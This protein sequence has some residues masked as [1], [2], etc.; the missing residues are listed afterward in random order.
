[1]RHEEPDRVPRDL[2]A[3]PEAFARLR[4]ALGVPND[5]AVLERCGIDL[6]VVPGPSY[7]GQ[8]L[9]TWDTSEGRVVEDLWGVRRRVQQV[10]RGGIEW[11]YK[12]LFRSPLAD[13]ETPADVDAYPGWPDPEGWDF[14]ALRAQCEA[15]RARGCAVVNAGDRLDRTAQL[16]TLMY[17]RGMEQAYLDLAANLPLVEA[18]LAHV[19]EYFLAYNRRVFEVAGDLIDV[20]MMG[21]DFGTQRGPI[22]RPELWRRLFRPGLRA[23]IDLAHQHGIPVMHHTCGSVVALIPDFIECGLD[24]LQSLQPGAEGMDLGRLKREFGCDL[25]FHGS[26][27]I[28]RTFP[29]GTPADVR[30]E[31]RRRM[32]AGQPGGGF[33]IAPAHALQ[34][35]VPPANVEAFVDACD[36]FGIH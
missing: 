33:I 30:E 9:R 10:C 2:W 13:A 16:K 1:L 36:E 24:I 29:F 34:P 32:E 14:S 4:H 35:D 8:E 3:A 18:I 12:H 6:R 7:A 26:L 31:V 20:F 27:D 19:T 22:M 23:Y 25:C 17:L 11:T 28:Q 21:D 15:V 5:E